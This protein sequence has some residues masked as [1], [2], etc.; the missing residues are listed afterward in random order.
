MI[1][2]SGIK[3]SQNVFSSVRITEWAFDNDELFL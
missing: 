3:K 2:I 1:T